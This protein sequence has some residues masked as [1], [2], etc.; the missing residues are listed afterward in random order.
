VRRRDH[1]AMDRHRLAYLNAL[2]KLNCAYCSYC[3]GLISY[4][5]EIAGRTELYWCPIR[6]AARLAG[7]HARYR[8]FV[9]CGDAE[10]YL[11]ESE[12]LR[13]SLRSPEK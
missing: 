13:D 9:D 11:R 8:D 7:T 10:A 3:N 6:H 4:V 12:P 2:Q 1:I 5:R